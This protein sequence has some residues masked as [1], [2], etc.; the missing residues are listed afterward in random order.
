MARRALTAKYGENYYQDAPV[1]VLKQ[2]AAPCVIYARAV[3]E[4]LGWYNDD[5]VKILAAGGKPGLDIH[6]IAHLSGGGII[7]KFGKP[8][9][10]K[11]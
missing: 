3:A 7:E 8:F 9:L 1:E 11:H 6:A 2:V 10:L 4:A 5:L